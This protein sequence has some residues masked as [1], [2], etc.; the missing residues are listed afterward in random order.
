MVFAVA[1]AV[2][3]QGFTFL[4]ITASRGHLSV[5]KELLTATAGADVNA[6]NNQVGF[7]GQLTNCQLQ[8]EQILGLKLAHR[9]HWSSNPLIVRPF[10]RF[11]LLPQQHTALILACDHGHLDILR[12]LLNYGADFNKEDHEVRLIP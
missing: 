7:S 12:L 4:M 2:P 10:E 11:V 1:I 3:M 6:V 9:G 5:A 8:H